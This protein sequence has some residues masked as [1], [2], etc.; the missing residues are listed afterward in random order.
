M[1][2]YVGEQDADEL[3]PCILDPLTRNVAQVTV[4]DVEE[5]N[6][7]FDI[8]MGTNV[9]IRREWLLQHSEEASDNVW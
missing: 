9:P 6:R 8:L 3:G 1:E 5:A 4:E 2:L 7:L